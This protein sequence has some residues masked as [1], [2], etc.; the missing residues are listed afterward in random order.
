M[1]TNRHLS[2]SAAVVSKAKP[3]LTSTCFLHISKSIWGVRSTKSHVSGNDED[4][5]DS[6]DKKEDNSQYPSEFSSQADSKEQVITF[7]KASFCHLSLWNL[8]MKK[9]QFIKLTEN[10]L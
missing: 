7:E 3:I 9:H 5:Y 6:S 4:P 10:D 8:I 1:Y 2:L